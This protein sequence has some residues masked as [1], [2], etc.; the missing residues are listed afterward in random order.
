MYSKILDEDLTPDQFTFFVKAILLANPN[1]NV[2]G[3]VDLSIRQLAGVMHMARSTV[4]A[5]YQAL[6]N[7]GMITRADKGFLINKYNFYQG[8]VSVGE[9]KVSVGK[10]SLSP[11]VSVGKD[12][13]S[14]GKDKVSVGKDN[15]NVPKE[16]RSNK[17]DKEDIIRVFDFWN[18]QKV[19]VHRRLTDDIRKRISAKLRDYPA[20]DVCKA[21]ANYAEIVLS[22]AYWWNHKWTIEDFLARGLEKFLDGEIAKQNYRGKR[23]GQTGQSRLSREYEEPDIYNK[24]TA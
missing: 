1:P 13:V 3:L 10:D 9:D 2:R 11:K 12:K 14:V 22:P 5:Q 8:R 16:E 19:V 6:L 7:K 20:D 4:Y 21:I 18:S 24:S 15:L 23:A 17:E